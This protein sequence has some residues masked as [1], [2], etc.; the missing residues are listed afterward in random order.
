[1]NN[2]N[3]WA[4]SAV[5]LAMFIAVVATAYALIPD[6]QPQKTHRALHTSISE[7]HK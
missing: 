1:M 6:G 2:K 5:C 7:N 4:L 3:A